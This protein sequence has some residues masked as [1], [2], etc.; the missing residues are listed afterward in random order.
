MRSGEG[1]KGGEKDGYEGRRTLMREGHRRKEKASHEE[2]RT[3]MSGE[4][5]N[6]ERRTMI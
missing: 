2:S 4:E 6:K 3:E 5:Q 1:S